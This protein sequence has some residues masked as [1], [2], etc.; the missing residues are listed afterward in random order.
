LLALP[1]NA[2]MVLPA[3]G[4]AVGVV[5]GAVEAGLAQP[6][7]NR[8]DRSTNSRIGTT[9]QVFLYSFISLLF[10]P[11]SSAVFSAA[12][13]PDVIGIPA[14]LLTPA[15]RGLGRTAPEKLTHISI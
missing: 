3:N 11:G 2:V 15:Y 4:E 14:V 7:I 8:K 6:A 9:R 5:D 12:V 13:D 10:L 1:T